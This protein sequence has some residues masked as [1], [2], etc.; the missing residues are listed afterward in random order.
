MRTFCLKSLSFFAAGVFIG[1]GIHWL[2]PVKGWQRKAEKAAG[3]AKEHLKRFGLPNSLITIH[4]NGYSVEYDTRTRNPAWV[5]EHLTAKELSVGTEG[6]QFRFREDPRIPDPFRTKVEDFLNTTFEKGHLCPPSDQRT[7]N[8]ALSDTFYLSNVSPQVPELKQGLWKK[9]ERQ[10]RSWTEIYRGL[11]VFTGPLYLPKNEGDVRIVSY[12]VI[13][14]NNVAVPTHFFK[15]IF[16]EKY[17]GGYISKAY[18]VPNQAIDEKTPLSNFEVPL[19]EVEKASGLL[20][21]EKL[22]GVSH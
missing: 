15:V 3:H 16:A 20:F 11:D 4:R 13:G 18:I 22:K 7:G 19:E 17:K 12:P 14:K 6:G 9:L 5:Y 1:L 8:E 10:V 2:P 21:F